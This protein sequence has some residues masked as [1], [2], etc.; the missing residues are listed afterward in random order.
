MTICFSIKSSFVST[1]SLWTAITISR[2]H[3]EELITCMLG[4][5]CATGWK[6]IDSYVYLLQRNDTKFFFRCWTSL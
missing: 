3:T 1:V 5:R 2:K 6:K 4:N